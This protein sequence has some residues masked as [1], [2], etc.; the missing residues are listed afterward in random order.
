M[1]KGGTGC[2]V[3]AGAAVGFRPCELAVECRP[4]GGRVLVVVSGELDLDTDRTLGRVL[5]DAIDRCAEGVDLDLGQVAFA[6][7]SGLNVLL[8]MRQLA[9]GDGKTLTV[10]EAGPAVERLFEV[11][12][13]RALFVPAEEHRPH[14]RPAGAPAVAEDVPP[15]EGSPPR[16]MD[17]QDTVPQD[18]EQLRV[19]VGQL[20][21][22][23]RTRPTIDL[24][25]G[26]LM[27]SF[28]LSPEEAWHLLV[29]VSQRTN[30]KL[31]RLADDLLGTVRG[32]ALAEHLQRELGLAV[33]A[34]RER[35]RPAAP[36]DAGGAPGSRRP[37]G[38]R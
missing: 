15:G 6:D 37:Q 23:M 3:P 4:D 9:L 16:D 22:A 35:A 34:L 11:T 26:I 21:R 38:T 8:A 33:S 27:A 18:L 1:G 30:V 17:P 5:R 24:A 14:V 20:R 13:T 29:T 12:G 25:R 7:C 2:A 32:D 19:E 28:R 36:A 10:R 31:H